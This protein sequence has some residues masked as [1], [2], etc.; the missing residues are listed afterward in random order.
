MTMKAIFEL[1][2]LED[3]LNPTRETRILHAMQDIDSFF[4]KYDSK[5]EFD[6]SKILDLIEE[7]TNDLSLVLDMPYANWS[8]EHKI[9]TTWDITCQCSRIVNLCMYYI[10]LWKHK[11][12][13]DSVDAH[14]VAKWKETLPEV[15]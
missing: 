1:G 13:P 2:D 4:A 6:S 11:A 5:V 10:I 8:V 9:D 12:N 7:L 15:H 14:V 3:L